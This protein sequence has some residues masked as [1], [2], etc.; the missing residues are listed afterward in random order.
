MTPAPIRYLIKAITLLPILICRQLSKLMPRDPNRIAIGAWYGTLYAD[1]SKYLVEFLI[2]NTGYA[3]TWIGNEDV[4]RRLPRHPNLSFARKGSWR[5][6]LALL[7]AKFWICCIGHGIDLSPLPIDGGAICINL[8]HGI[9]VKRNGQHTIWD[10]RNKE[11]QGFRSF[12][13]RLYSYVTAGTKEWLLVASEEM[14]AIQLAYAPHVFTAKRMLRSGSPRNDYLI[15]NKDNHA[16]Q[17]DLRQK[18]ASLLRFDPRK[19]VILY[20]PTWRLSGKN[21]FCFYN[22]PKEEQTKIKELLDSGN[23]T[24]IEKH[25][26]HTYE[27]HPVPDNSTCSLTI[28]GDVIRE[29]DA[30]ELLLIADILI[31]DY[32]GA[33]IDYGL[34]Q[35]PCIHFAYDLEEFTKNDSGLAYAIEDVAAGPI[36]TTLPELKSL[37][38]SELKTPGFKPA[39]H[40][41]ELVAFETGSSCNQL[42]SFLGNSNR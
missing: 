20:L 36:A 34:L 6:T 23:A 42:V 3:V 18:Y 29:T 32:S 4:A 22:L 28:N 8:W 31:C 13:E 19:K 27:R 35:R 30:Q 41:K 7:K 10:L 26:F 38:V 24:L 11:G 9:P 37:L 5:A 39:K 25:H 21:V 16:L 15:A 1:N 17:K 33:Y 2:R 40:F 12:L 14:I